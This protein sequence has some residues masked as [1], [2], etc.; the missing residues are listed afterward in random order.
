MLT[1]C[2]G[3]AKCSAI[4]PGAAWVRIDMHRVG[5]IESSFLEATVVMKK[6][7]PQI[8]EDGQGHFT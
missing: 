2:W 3:E 4:R 5:R 7:N 8:I 1:T 6:L